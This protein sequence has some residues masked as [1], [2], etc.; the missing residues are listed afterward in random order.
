MLLLNAQTLRIAYHVHAA[1][2]G[3]AP[4]TLPGSQAPGALLLRR[5]SAP[6]SNVYWAG[7]AEAGVYPWLQATV[8]LSPR[9]SRC[10]SVQLPETPRNREPT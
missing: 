10:P 6:H 5:P 3:V 9:S 2:P 1:N 8:Q 4:F 7:S